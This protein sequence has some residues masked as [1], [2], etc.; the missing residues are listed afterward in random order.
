MANTNNTTP[1]TVPQV[2]IIVGKWPGPNGNR[3]CI[4]Q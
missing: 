2:H 1:T 4:V 3:H